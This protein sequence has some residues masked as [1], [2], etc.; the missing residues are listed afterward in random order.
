MAFDRR[1][2][3]AV[4][5]SELC[6]V[7]LRLTAELLQAHVHAIERGSL[8]GCAL[9]QRLRAVGDL[10]RGRAHL[11]SRVVH[12]EQRLIERLGGRVEGL[13][14]GLVI[15]RE[16]LRHARGQVAVRHRL[17]RASRSPTG[18]TMASRVAFKPLTNPRKAPWKCSGA[19]RSASRPSRATCESVPIAASSERSD[20]K[21]QQREAEHQ[22]GSNRSNANRHVSSS[23]VRP[24]GSTGVGA[25]DRSGFQE[26]SPD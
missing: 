14:Q 3:S 17:Q 26:A 7:L 22:A 15:P 18:A 1:S 5:R 16:M 12:F 9:R 2:I 19:A 8:F 24:T 25:H 23:T 4:P 20:Q 10:R 21:E 13:C 6:S 11:L